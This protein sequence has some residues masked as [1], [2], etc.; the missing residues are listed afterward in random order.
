MLLLVVKAVWNISSCQSV[1]AVPNKA[2]CASDPFHLLKPEI[3]LHS[4]STVF[5]TV[6]T[7]T[8]G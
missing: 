5:A 3:D 8:W 4:A 7:P 1:F 2:C 6:L